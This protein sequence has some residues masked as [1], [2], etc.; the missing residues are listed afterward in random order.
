MEKGT[1]PV[2]APAFAGGMTQ[3]TERI[4]ARGFHL[5]HVGTEIGEQ[6]PAVAPGHALGELEHPDPAQHLPQPNT[7][8]CNSSMNSEEVIG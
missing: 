2:F 8:Y 3:V 7:A 4:A 1:S 5:H 6:L